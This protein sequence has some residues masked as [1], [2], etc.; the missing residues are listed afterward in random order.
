MKKWELTVR[1]GDE[2]VYFNPN[3]SLKQP[4]LSSYD[5]EI[6][7]TKIFVSYEL[8]TACN[9]QN[10]MNENEM[11]FQYIEHLEVEIMKSDFKLKDSLFSV[12][13]N[14]AERS[15]SY[16]EKVAEEKKAQRV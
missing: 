10:S 14:S 1:V 2:A 8:T 3:H 5:F 9:F 13:E 16:E 4:E 11:N 6:I 7:E 12:R 15:N